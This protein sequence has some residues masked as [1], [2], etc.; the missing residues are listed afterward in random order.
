MIDFKLANELKEAG[1]PQGGNGRWTVD[2]EQLVARDRAYVP[3][4]E[5][6]IEACREHQGM[7]CLQQAVV[8]AELLWQA[9][10]FGSGKTRS[11]ASSAVAAVARLWLDLNKTA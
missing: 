2:P 7:F 10:M 9:K 8:K 1:F 3:T 11:N 5:E 6:L 4:L